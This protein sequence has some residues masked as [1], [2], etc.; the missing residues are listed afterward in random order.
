MSTNSNVEERREAEI[1][2]KPKLIIP[3]FLTPQ[4]FKKEERKIV[5]E[6]RLRIRR[7]KD[8]D[9]GR[10]KINPEIAKELDIKDKIEVV[11]VGGGSRVRRHIFTVVLSDEVPKNEVWCNEDELKKYGIADNTIATIRAYKSS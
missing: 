4:A 7:R 5:K 1:E 9:E 2:P 10:A 8:V 11:V 6:R 3:T